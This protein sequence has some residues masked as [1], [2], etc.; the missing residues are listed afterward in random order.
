[1]NQ[2]S[3]D[4]TVRGF[5][6]FLLSRMPRSPPPV[7]RNRFYFI[8]ISIMNQTFVEALEELNTQ[9]DVHVAQWDLISETLFGKPAK[10]ICCHA[11][12]THHLLKDVC[13]CC[14]KHCELER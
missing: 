1:M 10:S 4:F 7:I 9:L 8:P 5:Y 3:A 6:F 11:E 13:S 2:V 12:V 14:L